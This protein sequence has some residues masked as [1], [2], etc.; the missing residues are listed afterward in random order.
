M[1]N[2]S[3]HRKIQI[4][5]VLAPVAVVAILVTGGLYAIQQTQTRPTQRPFSADSSANLDESPAGTI[6]DL[7]FVSLDGKGTQLSDIKAKIIMVNFWATW[8]EACMEEMPSIVKVRNLFK[9]RGFEVVGINLDENPEVAIP[10]ALKKFKIEFPVFQDTDG[11]IADLFEVRAI[12]LTVIIDHERKV[13]LVK[14]GEQDWNSPE[15]Q[16]QLEKWLSG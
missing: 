3:P 16:K 2:S 15:F 1:A 10:K 13:R 6:P 12:P 4:W 7:T 8:C 11:K 14:D 5:K 9:D